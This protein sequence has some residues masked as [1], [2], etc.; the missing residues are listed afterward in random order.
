MARRRGWRGRVGATAIALVALALLLPSWLVP[1][2]AGQPAQTPEASADARTATRVARRALLI[3]NDAY[4]HIPKLGN[5]RTDARALGASLAKLGY[6]VT[7]REDLDEKGMKAA[8]RQFRAEVEGGDEV[9]FFYAGHGVQIG[10]ANFLLPIDIRADSEEQVKDEAVELQRV[11]ED[12]A[13]RRAKLTIAIVDACRDNPFPVRAGRSIG[14]RG[15]APTTAATG[16]MVIFSAGAGQQALDRLGP[17]DA[18]PNGLFTRT[19]LREIGTPGLRV[20]NVV[21][22]V[23]KKVVEAARAV[24][25]DQV[26]AIYDQIVGDFYF[27]PDAGRRMAAGTGPVAS[28]PGGAGFDGTWRVGV[29]CH[30]APDGAAG[31]RFTFPMRVEGGVVEGSF[32]DRGGLSSLTMRGRIEPDGRSLLRVEGLTGDTRYSVGRAA[33]SSP[34]RYTVSARFDGRSGTGRRNEL[35]QCDFTFDRL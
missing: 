5:A 21:R 18:D 30:T 20:D 8:L 10:A 28:A 26:P 13:A 25:H 1:P 29:V 35:R 4:R 6:Q 7:V 32:V 12:L 24:G 3:G 19:L 33:P 31:Y 15:L 34:Y 2:A 22:E 14:G 16:Q 17:N 23:R 9:V 11:L 27:V